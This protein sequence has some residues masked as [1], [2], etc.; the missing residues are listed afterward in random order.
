VALRRRCPTDAPNYTLGQLAAALTCGRGRRT[1]RSGGAGRPPAQPRMKEAQEVGLRVSI[2]CHR[3]WRWRPPR[4]CSRSRPPGS[5]ASEAPAL[6]PSSSTQSAS[7][8]SPTSASASSLLRTIPGG[9]GR[10]S[11][12]AIRKPSRLRSGGSASV[13]GSRSPR[14][15][16][17]RRL[18]VLPI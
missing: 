16:V 18:P 1:A 5:T 2:T 12:E 14:N 9:S 8:T 6:K 13:T 11:W 7:S 4:S 17:F 15:L 10:R 3:R